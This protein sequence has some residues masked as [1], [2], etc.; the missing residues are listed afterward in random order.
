MVVTDACFRALRKTG[1]VLKNARLPVVSALK[2]Y[3]TPA[4]NN[5][6]V[7]SRQAT[8]PVTFRKNPMVAGLL[9]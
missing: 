6:K 4:W 7:W 8:W 2:L 5:K 1:Q 3:T 9:F